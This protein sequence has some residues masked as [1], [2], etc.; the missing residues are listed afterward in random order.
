[1]EIYLHSPVS[2]HDVLLNRLST[3]KILQVFVYFPFIHVVCSFI[4]TC[5]LFNDADNNWDYTAPNGSKI[6]E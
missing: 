6:S 2:L 3:G 4:V 5:G 1:M